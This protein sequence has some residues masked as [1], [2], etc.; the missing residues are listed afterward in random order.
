MGTIEIDTSSR[1]ITIHSTIIV[2]GKAANYEI[3]KNIVDEIETM[4]NEPN[5]TIELYNQLY[6]IRFSITPQHNSVL[7]PESVVQNENPRNNYIRIEE[8]SKL[9]ISYMDGIG[10]NSGYFMLANLYKGS[11]T[12]AHEYGH[13]LSLPH[14]KNLDIVGKGIPGIM[15]PRGTLVSQEFQNDVNAQPGGPGGTLNPQHRRVKQEDIEHLQIDKHILN[16]NFVLG[17]FTN[18]YHEMHVKEEV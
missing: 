5:G 16:E 18:Q 4:W 2:Y 14:P 3:G 12:A 1:I 15:Y 7:F 10:S 8:Y 6:H 9:N 13:S 11:T 17:K